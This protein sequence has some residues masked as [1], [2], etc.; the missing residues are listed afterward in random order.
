MKTSTASLYQRSLQIILENQSTSGAYVAC[1]NFPVYRYCWFR[2]SSFIAY[3]MDLA[4]YHDSA[5]RFHDWAARAINQRA[6]V[7]IRAVEKSARREPLGAKDT[8]HTRY[9]LEGL[10]DEG[11]P[12]P[13]GVGMV[14]WENHQIDGFG[15]WLW[16]LEQHVKLSGIPPSSAWMDAADLTSRYLQALWRQPCYDCWEEFPEHVHTYTLAAVYGGLKAYAALS[17]NEESAVLKEIHAYILDAGVN[18]GMFSKAVGLGNI[19]ASL[20]G[21]ATPFRVVEPDDPL[22]IATIDCIQT[23]LLRE[24]GVHRYPEDTYYG[25]GEWLLLAGWLGWYQVEVGKS[26]QAKR[27]LQW[28]EEQADATGEMPEQVPATLNNANF[29]APWVERWGPIAK[30]LLWSHAMYVILVHNLFGDRPGNSK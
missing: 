11:A 4:G 18:D 15:A 12:G 8:L 21:L 30:P 5:R 26:D 14:A 6:E 25:G 23:R 1:P 20:L 7:V 3:A 19:D 10:D 16:A 29:L 9:T 22:M 28:I 27:L 2:D 17:G 13:Q 24:G